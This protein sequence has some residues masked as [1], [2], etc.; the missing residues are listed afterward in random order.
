[1]E[2]EP[3]WVAAEELLGAVCDNNL[4][5]CKEMV[6]AK[7]TSLITAYSAGGN[8][9]LHLA[10]NCNHL[11]I[12][13]WFLEHVDRNSLDGSGWTALMVAAGSGHSECVRLLLQIGADTS[14]AERDGKT[15][16]DLAREEHKEEVVVVL[17]EHE[18]YLAQLGSHTKPALREPSARQTQDSEIGQESTSV[19]GADL[20][21]LNLDEQS[22]IQNTLQLWEANRALFL[23]RS[24]GILVLKAAEDYTEQA[25]PCEATDLV[26]DSAP[27]LG[28]PQQ[29]R[30]SVPVLLM[31]LSGLDFQLPE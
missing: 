16:L 14:I 2:E 22:S 18:R 26:L 17:E 25:A 23:C 29:L 24:T 6:R 11:E 5:L 20:P 1:M 30:V 10:A 28:A 7:G 19:T 3:A 12:L 9:G 27:P 4:L 15:A 21:L 13:Q 31:D 8:T